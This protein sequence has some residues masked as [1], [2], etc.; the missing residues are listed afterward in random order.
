MTGMSR[1]GWCVP[2]ARG[3]GLFMQ[4]TMGTAEWAMLLAL[5]V[6]WGGSFFFISVA[7][8]ELPPLTIVLLRVGIAALVL[9]AALLT[10]RKPFPVDRRIWLSFLAMGFLNNV[11]PQ[12]L[13]VWGQKEIPGGLASILNATTPLF[14]VVVAH[15]FTQDEKMTANKLAGLLIGL[16]GVAI[17]IG[18]SAFEGLGRN[19]LAEVA[20]LVASI[21][22]ALSGVYGRR[23]RRMGVDPIAIA[24]GQ[25][26]GSTILLLPLALVF[27]HPL[28]LAM[29]SLA[30]WQ[31]VLGLALIS[32]A[33]AYVIFFRILATAGATNLLLVTFLIPVSAIFL[34]SMFLGEQLE[35]KHF[36][37]MVCIAAGLACI[38]GRLLRAFKPA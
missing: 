6:L 10:L 16:A 30:A 2:Q 14:G 34:G 38:D 29:P 26:T 21:F 27:E 25:L 33:L 31:A 22:Y 9:Y 28:S 35:P 20:V 3:K 19:F 7:V 5:S 15:Y 13:I 36:F 1:I 4:K 11:I 32:T 12:T 24:A 23:F 18:P 17:M 8:K 37:G